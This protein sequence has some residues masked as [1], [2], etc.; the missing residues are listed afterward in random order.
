MK[1]TT[2]TNHHLHV[3]AKNQNG[4]VNQLS[5]LYKRKTYFAIA[6]GGSLFGSLLCG[7]LTE[8]SRKENSRNLTKQQPQKQHKYQSIFTSAAARSSAS[9]FYQYEN[10][11]LR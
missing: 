11:V 1:T 8:R 2:T 9:A 6:G 10:N 7:S 3:Y 4:H 5:I